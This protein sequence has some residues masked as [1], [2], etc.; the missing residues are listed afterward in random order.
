MLLHF[1]FALTQVIFTTGNLRIQNLLGSSPPVQ[2]H[3]YLTALKTQLRR[4]LL[5]RGSG[6]YTACRASCA[7]CH[8]CHACCLPH[9]H[10]LLT[11]THQVCRHVT[12]QVPHWWKPA[13]SHCC[14]GCAG[15]NVRCIQQKREQKESKTTH[16]SLSQRT[17]SP[18]YLA[19]FFFTASFK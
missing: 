12:G 15:W 19:T 3:R 9:L 1:F 16:F 17:A 14:Y 7:I 11:G 8:R 4:N 6:K 10:A 5:W 18:A 13:L 2:S